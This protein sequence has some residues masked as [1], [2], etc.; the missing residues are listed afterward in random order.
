MYALLPALVASDGNKV[1]CILEKG[2][3]N[4]PWWQLTRVLRSEK[5]AVKIT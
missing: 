5:A 2:F 4:R 3:K 1:K